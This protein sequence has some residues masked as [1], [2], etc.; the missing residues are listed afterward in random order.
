MEVF[1]QHFIY[2]FIVIY[3]ADIFI[4]LFIYL[5]RVAQYPSLFVFV[6]PFLFMA[7]WLSILLV[8]KQEPNRLNYHN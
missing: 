1:T 3:A 2:L 4:Y 7:T 8:N 5:F 6:V